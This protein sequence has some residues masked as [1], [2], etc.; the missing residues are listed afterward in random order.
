MILIWK[1]R[2]SLTW[3]SPFCDLSTPVQTPYLQQYK[4]VQPEL[5]KYRY[6]EPGQSSLKWSH[7][8]VKNIMVDYSLQSI[9]WT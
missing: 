8:L 4:Q 5:E 7:C 6:K 1:A 3:L 2:V 9:S